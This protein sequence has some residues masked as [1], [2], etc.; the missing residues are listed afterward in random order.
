MLREAFA[1]PYDEVAD[2]L[3]PDADLA[4]GSDGDRKRVG[5][6]RADVAD[7][8]RGSPVDEALG[9]RR[10]QVDGVRH[11]GRPE[12]ARREQHAVRPVEPRHQT[13]NGPG[14]RRR[15]HEE[16]RHE[17]DSDHGQHR[18]DHALERPL[19]AGLPRNFILSLF[20][21]ANGDLWVGDVGQNS[22]E[23]VSVTRA[24]NSAGRNFG[25]NVFE[26]SQPYSGD[27]QPPGAVLPVAG[28]RH[29]VGGQ[30]DLHLL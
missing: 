30:E 8:D 29:G 12:H 25:W 4:V 18:G 24:G 16:P 13:G 14:H 19:T 26:G 5:A 10:V 11:H 9:Q 22:V 2:R 28:G 3:G 27:T 21:A 20:E 15:R 7:E 1:L 6:A 17:P 23:E